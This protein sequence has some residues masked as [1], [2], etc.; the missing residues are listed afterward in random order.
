MKRF[1]V[2]LVVGLMMAMHV[3]ACDWS[4]AVDDW[5]A[6]DRL[7]RS[8]LEE[9]R[10]RGLP[11]IR[12]SLEPETARYPEIERKIQAMRAALPAGAPDTVELVDS[13]VIVE[14]RK[15]TIKLQYVVRNANG[16][17]RAD[18]WVR[19]HRGDLKVET[20]RVVS[21]GDS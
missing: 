7:A 20:L 5:A 1:R 8:T 16:A 12:G 4:S 21:L 14:G 17:A 11:G 15:S 3:A 13:E 6:A 18:V 19:K 9:L 2:A 10:S